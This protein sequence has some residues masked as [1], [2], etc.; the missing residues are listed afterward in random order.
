MGSNFR[1]AFG[2][3]FSRRDKNSLAYT[4][5]SQLNVSAD[6]RNVELSIGLKQRMSFNHDVTT[7]RPIVYDIDV[8]ISLPSA[9]DWV[10]VVL[11]SNSFL[12]TFTTVVDTWLSLVLS[13]FGVISNIITLVVFTK[14]GFKDTVNITMTSITLWDL[15]RV[16]CGSLHR[17]Y[18]PMSVVSEALGT[19]WQN[20]TLTNIVYLHIVAGNISYVIGGYVALERCLCVIA[21]FKVRTIIT[22]KIT[23]IVCWA[24]SICVFASQLPIFLVFEYKW[25][26]SG[27]YGQYIAIYQ[28][29]Q[30]YN[31][32]GQ[33]F[34]EIYR[35]FSFLYPVLSLSVMVFSTV[36]I[37]TSF[38]TRPSSGKTVPPPPPHLMASQ[39]PENP[40]QRTENGGWSRCCWWSS[41]STWSTLFPGWPTSSSCCQRRSTTP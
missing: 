12:S 8:N 30:F 15:V 18:G 21:P 35:Y 29:T 24:I 4:S 34:M 10:K 39:I 28:Y 5:S 22:P 33:K 3:I 14:L 17:L 20:I 7:L 11:I 2:E 36:I 6:A 23:T 31:V 32:H 38:K 1:K 41:P 26:F 13:T 25:V 16:L 9:I 27:Q 37:S 40:S 19:S